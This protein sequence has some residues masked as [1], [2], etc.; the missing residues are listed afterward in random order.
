MLLLLVLGWWNGGL[1][2]DFLKFHFGE[3]PSPQEPILLLWDDFSGHWTKQVR[4]Y[5][6]SVNIVL[7]KVP[8]HATGVSQ[9]ADVAWNYPFKN[10]LRRCWLDN[11]QSQVAQHRQEDGAFRLAPPKRPTI[12]RWIADSWNQLSAMTIANGYKKAGILP[13]EECVAAESL[14]SSLEE[15]HV[16]EGSVISC[17]DEFDL[18]EKI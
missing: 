18:S 16:I 5:A 17:D 11:L 6:A 13:S 7:L 9:P 8:P 3:R 4:E 2:T 10:H 1:S 12:S 14:I 15:L